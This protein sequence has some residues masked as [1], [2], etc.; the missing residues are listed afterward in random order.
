MFVYEV[1]VRVIKEEVIFNQLVLG[2]SLFIVT[3]YV[4]RDKLISDSNVVY[5]FP[6][7]IDDGKV[8]VALPSSICIEKSG[9]FD[10]VN[11]YDVSINVEPFII[12]LIV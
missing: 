10:E 6:T 11:E 8:L 3:V 5:V 12:L 1:I 2:N 7:T 9:L 4:P